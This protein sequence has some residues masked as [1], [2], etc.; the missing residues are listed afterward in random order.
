MQLVDLLRTSNVENTISNDEKEERLRVSR[1]KKI[2]KAIIEY[3]NQHGLIPIVPCLIRLIAEP[4]FEG[5]I[6]DSRD[7]HTIFS[8]PKLDPLKVS[9]RI[10]ADHRPLVLTRL[11]GGPLKKIEEIG[12]T[13]S[14]RR[15]GAFPFLKLPGELRNKVYV[16]MLRPT[17][18]YKDLGGKTSDWFNLAIF[19]TSRHMYFESSSVIYKQQ[20]TVVV[21][22]MAIACCEPG[23]NRL[24]GKSRFK[25]CWID[26]DMSDRRLAQGRTRNHTIHDKPAGVFALLVIELKSMKFLEE[27]RLS[28]KRANIPCFKIF[29]DERMDCFWRLKGLKKVVIEGDLEEAY[30]VKLLNEMNKPPIDFTTR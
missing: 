2:S 26:V 14:T 13:H 15:N 8:D 18:S 23:L 16:Y 4:G 7:F 9:E 20:I 17:V 5:C 28:C 3:H 22:P 6:D 29:S 11:A 1:V 21:D 25:R 12:S 19:C 27:L 30:V 24:P 10:W